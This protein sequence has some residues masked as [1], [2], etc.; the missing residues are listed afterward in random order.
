MISRYIVT[1]TDITSLDIKEKEE[2]Q[3]LKLAF[4]GKLAAGITHEINTPLTYIRG[5]LE[6]LSMDLDDD[7]SINKESYIYFKEYIDSMQDGVTRI[8]NIVDTMKELTVSKRNEFNEINLF[9][10]LIYALRLSYHSFKQV[11][12]ININNEIF[13]NDI[14]KDKYKYFI[15]A[16]PQSLEQVWI[17]LINNAIDVLKVNHQSFEERKL[18]ISITEDE[19]YYIVTIQDNAGGIQADILNNIFEPFVS[20]KEHAGMGLGLNIAKKIID[21]H[22]ATIKV[23]NKNN[24]AVFEL[25]FKKYE[26]IDF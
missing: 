25:R 12:S 4:I 11:C 23:F 16:T 8:A 20:T 18:D 2:R 5:N 15:L 22:Q 7:V 13:T 26:K 3:E 1:L 21:E 24:G 10:T 6:L 9:K 19:L 14:D 17:I